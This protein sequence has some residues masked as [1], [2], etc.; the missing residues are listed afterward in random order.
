MSTDLRQCP[1][2]QELLRRFG[3]VVVEELGEGQVGYI[4]RMRLL[5]FV[6]MTVI[7]R[8]KDPFVLSKA[9]QIS[10]RYRTIFAKIAP[11][12]VV[13]SE[14]AALWEEKLKEHGYS[15]DKSS[16]VPTKTLIVDLVASED[17]L[18]M[19]MK[20]K[21]RYNI[22]LSQRRGVTTEVVSGRAITKNDKYLDEF[23]TV[24]QQNCQRIGIRAAP[25]KWFRRLFQMFD[26]NL[27]VVYAY[28]ISGEPAAVACYMVTA[29]TVW[30]EMNGA[31]EE[32][33]HDFATN[34]VVW[35]G[36]LEGKKR[37][38][39]WLDFDGVYDER[40]DDEDWKGFTRFKVGFGGEEVT[41]LGS[42]VKW[43]PFL[44]GGRIRNLQMPG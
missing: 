13:G 23:H 42:Y 33:R 9:D 20:S 11:E 30:Y 38:C 19:Q 1:E 3:R 8:V 34:R 5:P 31:T 10:R 14:G 29:D 36:M 2:Y 28:V 41:Y 35:E 12:V 25:R 44:K 43:L 6:R 32:G 7:Q 39:R 26:E 21:T 4:M 16:I 27:F 40:Y 22:R 17:D 15:R 18:L 24:Y 37:G